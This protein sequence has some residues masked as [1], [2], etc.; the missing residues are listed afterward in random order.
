MRNYQDEKGD[1]PAPPTNPAA[2]D[3]GGFRVV[4]R[5]QIRGGRNRWAQASRILQ[6]NCI[7]SGGLATE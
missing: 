7:S 2:C 4:G 6:K 5:W 3:G 1:L